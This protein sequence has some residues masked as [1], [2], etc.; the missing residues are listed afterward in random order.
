MKLHYSLD[1]AIV[2]D[3]EQGKRILESLRKANVGTIWLWGFFFGKLWSPIPDMVR[4]AA[5]L[6]DAG[7]EVGVIQLPVG[8]PGNGLNPE[9]DSLDLKLPSHWRYR[10]S[11]EGEDVYYCAD[12][13]PNMIADN[14]SSIEQ[15]TK[16]GFTKFFMDDDLRM[17]NWGKDIEGSFDEQSIASFNA[18]YGWNVDRSEL[19]AIL[20]ADVQSLIKKDWV[21]YNCEKLAGFMDAMALPGTELGLM[22]MHLGDERHGIDI[23]ML[24]ERVPDCMFRVGESHFSDQVFQTPEDK[25]DEMFSMMLHLD[26]MGRDRT[27]SETTVFPPRALSEKHLVYKAQMALALG[28]PN[29]LFMSGTWLISESYWEKVEESRPQLL[30]L[31]CYLNAPR[32]YPVHVAYGTHG[33]VES[34]DVNLLPLFAGLPAIPMRSGRE[35]YHESGG[36]ECLLFF[37][38]QD[39]TPE[40][41]TR[42]AKYSRIIMDQTA[43]ERNESKLRSGGIVYERWERESDSGTEERIQLLRKKLADG[44][45]AFPSVSKG[46][47]VSLIWLKEAD[48]VILLNLEDK[49]KQ[50]ALTYLGAEREVEMGALEIVCLPLSRQGE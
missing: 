31:D 30:Q 44:N 37:G 40:W 9:D 36:G 24:N 22:V 18:A 21:R 43:I 38:A 23:S 29:I 39:I 3:E 35:V 25:A 8:H 2:L 13:E 11:R 46:D 26:A 10:V 32:A 19:H 5:V 48:T 1:S 15:L 50:A 6:R 7:F 16:E 42:F 28:I 41:E 49:P 34:I 17:G 33:Y 4:A 12:I 14:R 27:F 20:N 47:F 45:M